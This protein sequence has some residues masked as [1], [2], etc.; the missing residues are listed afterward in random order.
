MKFILPY[1]PHHGSY[2][3]TPDNLGPLIVPKKGNPVTLT[4]EN[5]PVYR[6]ILEANERRDVEVRND[7]VI[8]DG[9]AVSSYSFA[10]DYYW[11]VSDNRHRAMDSRYFGFVPFDHMIG[12]SGFVI[13]H[14]NHGDGYFWRRLLTT[15]K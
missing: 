9:I 7:R 4:K 10:Q 14:W 11:V 12:T 2:N 15:V 3:W 13:Y 8:I 5:L 6:R 1:F